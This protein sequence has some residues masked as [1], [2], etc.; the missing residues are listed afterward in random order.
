[1]FDHFYHHFIYEK[2]KKLRHILVCISEILKRTILTKKP[3]KQQF[4]SLITQPVLLTCSKLTIET[5]EQG[6]KYVQCVVLV[7]LL[8]TLNIF[9]TLF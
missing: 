6:V 5:L 4:T 1:M 3:R 7:S 2:V 9:H 8:L